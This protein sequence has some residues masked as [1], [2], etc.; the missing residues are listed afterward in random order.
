M[1]GDLFKR[2]KMAILRLKRNDQ[3]WKAAWG[4]AKSLLIR[5]QA[6]GN[7]VVLLIKMQTPEICEK[8]PGGSM[9]GFNAI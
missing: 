7:V 1:A 9:S 5:E 6:L 8:R 4:L 3:R 2:S